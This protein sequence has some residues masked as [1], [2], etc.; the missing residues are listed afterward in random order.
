M[1]YTKD[2]SI[3]VS[4][5][6]TDSE[7]D[8]GSWSVS[9]RGHVAK[10]T[11]DRT[12]VSNPKYREQIRRQQNAS[13]DMSGHIDTYVCQ[14]GVW[15]IVHADVNFNPPTRE[16]HIIRARYTGDIAGAQLQISWWSPTI[17][18]AKAQNRAS[19]AFLKK[20]RAIQKEFSS[21]IFLGELRQTMQMIRRPA[22]G[23]R[24]LLNNYM[25]DVKSLKKAKP[26][27][28]QKHLSE[29]WL[30]GMF[31]WNPLV[32]DLQDAY[33]AYRNFAEKHNN[34][35]L[36]VSAYG[37]EEKFVS[38]ES[39][40]SNG[41]CPSG[42]SN[43]ISAIRVYRGSEKAFVKYH[44]M[45]TRQVDTTSRDVLARIGFEPNEFL[46]TA[47]ELL[48][49]SF[50]VDY[51]SNIGD[52]IE[53]SAFTR[54]LLAWAASDTVTSMK[55]EGYFGIDKKATAALY[56]AHF[57]FVEGEPVAFKAERRTVNRYAVASIPS[58]SLDFEIPGSPFQ[59]AN[60]LALF[61]QATSVHPQS[62]KGRITR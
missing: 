52:V 41:S 50:L 35:Q 19:I 14:P 6:Y 61:A 43:T 36:P 47:W 42:A 4:K 51:F 1:A 29:T 55:K 10:L 11:R 7:D 39:S 2:K 13:T 62:F 56:G 44:G 20:C 9:R 46:P 25:R 22:A 32:H 58:P 8:A 26:K 34:E 21:P 5:I 54:S 24:N 27:G 17:T 3:Y 15:Y 31:G 48:P 23:L 40:S 37:I 16:D 49:W 57:R 60:M 18:T 33:K 28:W 30:E 53:A 59:Y 12:G 45:V 38:T